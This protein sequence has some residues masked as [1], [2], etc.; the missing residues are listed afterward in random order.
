MFIPSNKLLIYGTDTD[1]DAGRASLDACS[2]VS[3]ASVT[4]QMRIYACSIVA[5]SVVYASIDSDA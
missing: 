2:N 5:S 1:L 4:D 3:E